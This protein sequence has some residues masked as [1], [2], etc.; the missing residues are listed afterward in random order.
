MPASIVALR[1]GRR[2]YGELLEMMNIPR[3]SLSLIAASVR[4]CALS[5][6]A[7]AADFELSI[8]AASPGKFAAAEIRREAEARG[9]AVGEDP[10][11]TLVE[12][13]VVK[14]GRPAAQSYAVRVRN[15]GG[16]RIVTV[17]GGDEVGAMY[18]G[19]DVA[20]AIRTG[21][22]DSL[23]DSDH[24]PHVKQ[25]GIKFNIPL[26]LRTPSYSDCSDAAR[27]TSLRC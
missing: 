25:R 11:A 9:L 20:E 27:P 2:P 21:A 6:V 10:Q 26:D 24:R 17:R 18:G 4:A 5:D 3:V 23:K 7:L 13:T 19:L 8:A 15:D 12:L 16:R 14:E 1:I 22:L